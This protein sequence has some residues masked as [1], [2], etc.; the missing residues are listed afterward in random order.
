MVTEKNDSAYIIHRSLFYDGEGVLDN[1]LV[2]YFFENP[3]EEVT[4]LYRALLSQ[5]IRQ[6]GNVPS[7]T[8]GMFREH[9][10]SSRLLTSD[11]LGAML[12]ELLVFFPRPIFV[13]DGLDK[14]EKQTVQTIFRFIRSSSNLSKR[15]QLFGTSRVSLVINDACWD[16]GYGSDYA[17]RNRWRSSVK[18][19][20][21]PRACTN[22]DIAI[23]ARRDIEKQA[24]TWSWYAGESVA[25]KSV[26]RI[27]HR[28]NG[29]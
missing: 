2:Y 13:I 12:T 10:E 21:I 15:I 9:A 29:L 25:D 6:L 26:D 22:E 24:R 5:L 19:L 17:E 27:V 16:R 1:G 3:H 20:S 8:Q 14:A 11:Q 18:T 23:C 28:S 7:I 4:V